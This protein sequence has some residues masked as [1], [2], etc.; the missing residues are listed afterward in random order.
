MKLGEATCHVWTTPGLAPL[1]CRLATSNHWTCARHQ[2]YPGPGVIW[3]SGGE[4]HTSRMEMEDTALVCL[5][6][7]WRPHHGL[8]E[9]LL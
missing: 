4:G 8:Y 7:T 2:L 1:P 9:H 5:R 3:E 6:E